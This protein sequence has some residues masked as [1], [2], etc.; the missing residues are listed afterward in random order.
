MQKNFCC[1]EMGYFSQNHC[2]VHNSVFECPDSLIY[3]NESTGN[4][5]IIVHDGGESFINIRYCP[6]CGLEL[7]D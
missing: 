5:G 2:D 1:Y 6:W 4:Y 3:Y 7:K